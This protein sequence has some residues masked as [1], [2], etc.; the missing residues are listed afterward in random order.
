MKTLPERIRWVLAER[1]EG[2]AGEWSKA[3]GLTRQTVGTYL[4]RVAASERAGGAVPGMSPK[5]IS[6]LARAADVNEEW[7]AFGKRTPDASDGTADA[8]I[9]AMVAAGKA[10]EAAVHL[11]TTRVRFKDG[12]KSLPDDTVRKLLAAAENSVESF[13]RTV[14]LLFDEGP[15]DTDAEAADLAARKASVRRPVK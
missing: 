11:L 9:A 14:A 12:T 3:A 1:W 2:M 13:D 15:V 4:D 8:R 7:L 6:A 5:T 10:S